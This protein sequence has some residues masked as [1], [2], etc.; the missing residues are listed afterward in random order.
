MMG[1]GTG[2]FLQQWQF[3]VSGVYAFQDIRCDTESSK[4]SWTWSSAASWVRAWGKKDAILEMSRE[5]TIFNVKASNTR[6]CRCL[7]CLTQHVFCFT[8]KLWI[9]LSSEKLEITPKS[10]KL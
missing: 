5:K 2:N 1:L 7:T 6:E 3:L 4:S 9:S 10:C 8:Q